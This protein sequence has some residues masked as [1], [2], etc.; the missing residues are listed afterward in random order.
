MFTM[1]DATKKL[2]FYQAQQSLGSRFL[3]VLRHALV[4]C[5]KNNVLG[6]AKGAAYSALLALFPVLTALTAILVQANALAVSQNLARLVFVVV[7]PGTQE[8]LEYNFTQ[9]GQRPI[10]L[11]V[12]ATLLALWAASGLM[13]SLMQGFQLAYKL[14]QKRGFWHHRGV[15]AGLVFAGALPLV[16]ASALIVIGARAEQWLFN[17]LGITEGEPLR[18]WV[19]L[20]AMAA[21]YLAAT[22][23]IIAGTSCMYL[24]G[25]ERRT[26]WR[27]VWRGAVIATILYGLVT[28]AF[29]WSVR[30]MANYNVLYGSIGAVVALIVWMY[31]LSVIALFGCEYNA[32]RE[33]LD[34]Q[35]LL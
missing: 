29:G 24:A 3:M 6:V 16:L 4:S 23:A 33:R 14:P 28:T 27:T 26:S 13:M 7:P 18:G 17:F 2:F 8:I 19:S 9:R 30:N 15:A 1:Q 20:F 31:L 25:P 22:L 35:G 5:Y 21:R 32:A 12:T 10:Y 11:L 34:R